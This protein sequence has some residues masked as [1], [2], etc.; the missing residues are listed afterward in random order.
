MKNL[1]IT[2]FGGIELKI[3]NFDDEYLEELEEKEHKSKYKKRDKKLKESFA[4]QDLLT[5]NEI[6]KL[7]NYKGGS[8]V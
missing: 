4:L 8:D 3:N 5:E 7:I 2:Y 6:E 1:P